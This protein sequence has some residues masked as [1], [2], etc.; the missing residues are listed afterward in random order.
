MVRWTDYLAL[1]IATLV[2]LF[3]TLLHRQKVH[4]SV[5]SREFQGRLVLSSQILLVVAWILILL[6]QF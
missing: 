3:L 4:Q 1:L 2:V 6:V 5:R